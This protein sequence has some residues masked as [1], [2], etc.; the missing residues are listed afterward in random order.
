MNDRNGKN[1]SR[2]YSFLYSLYT[3]MLLNWDIVVCIDFDCHLFYAVLFF[4][5]PKSHSVRKSL[6]LR[7]LLVTIDI[8]R[9]R[10]AIKRQMKKFNVGFPSIKDQWL[11][12]KK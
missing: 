4:F 10:M 8:I 1:D 5:L 7:R 12:K 9:T 3:S 11:G 6:H 2:C